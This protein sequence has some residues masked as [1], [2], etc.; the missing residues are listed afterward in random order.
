MQANRMLLQIPCENDMEERWREVSWIM[1]QISSTRDRD[2]R[3]RQVT[4]I[5]GKKCAG[6]FH[7]YYAQMTQKNGEGITLVLTP[8]TDTI[9]Q[10]KRWEGKTEK[11]NLLC[12]LWRTLPHGLDSSNLRWGQIQTRAGSNLDQTRMPGNTGIITPEFELIIQLVL[13]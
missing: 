12:E 6:Y 3:L 4:Q 10:R 5:P 8:F 2:W 1:L 7:K 11:L 9:K 13:K